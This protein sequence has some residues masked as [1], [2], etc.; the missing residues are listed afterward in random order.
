MSRVTN[1]GNIATVPR[2]GPSCIGTPNVAFEPTSEPDILSVKDNTNT[3]PEALQHAGLQRHVGLLGALSLIVGSMIGSGIF[4]SGSAVAFRAGSAGM[5]LSVWAGCG[6]LVTLGA[7]CYA[8]LGTSIP[9]SGSEHTY[10]S[11][12]FGGLGGFMYSWVSNLILKPSAQ[13]GI[14]LTF[15]AYV[16]EALGDNVSCSD[17]KTLIVKLLSV[18]AIGKKV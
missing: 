3:V 7:L 14:S 11:A 6:V 10:L 13:A 9:K 12:A 1:A 15:G 4:A 2:E 5:L 17:H 8:E 16:M 18:F